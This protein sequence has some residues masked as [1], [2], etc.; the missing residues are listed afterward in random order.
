MGRETAKLE[1][2][3]DDNLPPSSTVVQNYVDLNLRSTIDFEIIVIKHRDYTQAFIIS[4]SMDSIRTLTSK[5][6]AKVSCHGIYNLQYFETMQ[7]R[8][9]CPPFLFVYT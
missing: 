5:T 3:K 6:A 4:K 9:R 2:G 1:N 8:C 7:I